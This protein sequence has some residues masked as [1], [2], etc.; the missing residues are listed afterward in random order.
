[1]KMN[2]KK[3]LIL[4]MMVMGI[5]PLLIMGV[6]SHIS[7]ENALHKM[8]EK[9][10]EAI[11]SIKKKQIETFFHDKKGD[12]KNLAH[13][14]NVQYITRDL[15]MAKEDLKPTAGDKYP[16]NNIMVSE[17]IKVY[18]KFFVN[19]KELYDY[20]DVKLISKKDGHIMYSAKKGKDL[21]ENLMEGNLKDSYLTKLYRKVLRTNEIEYED[22]HMYEAANKPILFM[23]AP[24]L[25]E[26]KEILAVLVLSIS[27]EMINKVTTTR[28]GYGETSE[29]YIVG[30]DYL[31][32]SDLYVD[33]SQTML[34]SFK[35]NKIIKT[36]AVEA[37]LNNEEGV[38]KTINYN[39]VEVLTG[40]NVIKVNG[41]KWAI[42]S[43]VSLSE[44][45]K[46]IVELRNVGIVVTLI[47]LVVIALVAI[48]VSIIISRPIIKQIENIAQ[49]A[50]EV[51]NASLQIS[52]GSQQ[53][54]E[55]SQQQA[56][57][58]EEITNS[59]AE[60]KTTIE[61][62]AE[63]AREADILSSDSNQAAEEG[64]RHVKEL[65]VSMSEI[66]DSSREIEKIIKTIDE[67]AFQT[68]LLAL[69]A[70]VEAARA[71]E[72]G[73][74]FAVVAEE[75]RSL[76]QRSAEAAKDTA[77][78]ISISI[79]QVRK[80]NQ[81]TN[82]TN[83]AFEN[84]L[85]KVKKT[86]DI[87]SEIALASKE[88]AT[89]IKQINDA[90]LQVDSVTQTMASG[91]EESA[92]ASEQLSA[93]SV[94]MTNSIKIIGEKFGLV[95]QENQPLKDRY[96]SK[97]EEIFVFEEP[98]EKVTSIQQRKETKKPTPKEVFPLDED[99]IKEF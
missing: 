52:D 1:M 55:A 10:L 77:Q 39:G 93:Q 15:Q 78:I 90:I 99:S 20:E 60:N 48:W 5:L 83:E 50:E 29:S 59:L 70:A 51:S 17:I 82:Q 66:I 71:G 46:P 2:F 75:V 3:Q 54:A 13:T 95:L 7:A 92:A 68:N 94:D 76:A 58:V 35:N 91:S 27:G 53:L 61:Q 38:M 84:I 36:P 85:D 24:V 37:A 72:H 23:A 86:K 41:H 14:D 31:L 73:L 19:F 63:N 34:S 89:S 57:S 25:G 98:I 22:F 87:T 4:V 67:I 69:N 28:A 74:G 8:A 97:K 11:S 96:V 81:I 30:D 80:G 47:A 45:D 62:N 12:L 56:A 44:I 33:K 64:Y 40:Y 79:E 16:I 65:E 9:K 21:G 88:Q 43:E 6:K 18:D 32:R 49:G 26:N 42:I